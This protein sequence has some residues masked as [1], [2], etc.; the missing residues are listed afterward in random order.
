MKALWSFGMSGTSYP[1]TQ[2]YIP[3][4]LNHNLH[5]CENFKSC[6][7][8]YLVIGLAFFLINVEEAQVRVLPHFLVTRKPFAYHWS[9]PAHSFVTM[10]VGFIKQL[11]K[12]VEVAM[13]GF[14]KEEEKWK[15]IMNSSV[16]TGQKISLQDNCLALFTYLQYGRPVGGICV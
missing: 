5:H 7:L 12:F 10:F 4:Y 9:S 8:C 6:S 11:A 3:E 13:P 1:L 15:G 14:R 16:R 2:L